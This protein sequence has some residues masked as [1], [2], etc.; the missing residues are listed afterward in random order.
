MLQGPGRLEGQTVVTTE[1]GAD[2]GSLATDGFGEVT[3]RFRQRRNTW[4]QLAA[5]TVDPVTPAAA[6]ARRP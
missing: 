2:R 5:G 3:F 1:T 4:R 6:L